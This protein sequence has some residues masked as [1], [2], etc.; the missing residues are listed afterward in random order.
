MTDESD[1][2]SANYSAGGGYNNDGNLAD[3]SASSAHLPG[4]DSHQADHSASSAYQPGNDSHPPPISQA[5]ADHYTYVFDQSNPS[6]P[7]HFKDEEYPSG[8][9]HGYGSQ[10]YISNAAGQEEPNGSVH[11]QPERSGSGDGGEYEECKAAAELAVGV[12]TSVEPGTY[13]L[14]ASMLGPEAVPL[15]A[16]LDW[17]VEMAHNSP[18]LEDLTKIGLEGWCN[19]LANQYHDMD[20]Q[21]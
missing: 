17:Y 14:G 7:G 16:A 3:H 20:S 11:E 5:E 6:D 2:E 4:D 10:D 9:D 13:T 8:I 18:A 21:H 19:D 1:Q 15:G 12:V